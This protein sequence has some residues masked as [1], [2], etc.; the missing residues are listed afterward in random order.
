MRQLEK[1]F[2]YIAKKKF[3]YEIIERGCTWLLTD[4][5]DMLLLMW[6][7]DSFHECARP[8]AGQPEITPLFVGRSRREKW[9]VEWTKTNTGPREDH[10]PALYK[11]DRMTNTEHLHERTGQTVV[12]RKG[13]T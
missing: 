3:P 11:I 8:W 9:F 2:Y 10:V 6:F 7:N 5:G 1:T 13:K 12:R 4:D